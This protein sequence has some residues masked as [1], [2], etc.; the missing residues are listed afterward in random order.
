MFKRKREN[1]SNILFVVGSLFALLVFVLTI[2][3]LVSNIKYGG[4]REHNLVVER[5]FDN[6]SFLNT[7]YNHKDPYTTKIPNLRDML[8]GP[9][10][11][12]L[13]PSLGDINSP[14]TMVVFSD[15]ECS[16]CAE[17]EKIL[18]KA[19]EK[20]NIR[21][22]W[23]DYPASDT[24]SR[25][26]QAAM[27]A[28]CAQAENAFWDYHDLLFEDNSNL[29]KSNLLKIAQKLHLDMDEFNDCLD[30]AFTSELVHDDMLE[31]DALGIN[32]IPFLYVNN[33][34]MLGKIDADDLDKLI[35]IEL[36]KEKK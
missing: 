26:Y 1:F 16:Y 10:I 3:V 23:K 30:N 21:L 19:L 17:Q 6:N 34:E 2:S 25:S 15:F 18:K 24:Q 27:A 12:N 29:D 4:D 32:G 33:Q 14:V 7:D 36:Q 5:G 31:A 8:A 11:T 9:I 35:E 28:R 20:Y 13:D 22:V